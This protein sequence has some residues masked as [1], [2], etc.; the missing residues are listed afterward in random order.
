MTFDPWSKLWF[1]VGGASRWRFHAFTFPTN[2]QLAPLASLASLVS[3]APLA[4]TPPTR[5][6]RAG[7]SAEMRPTCAAAVFP[8]K[9]TSQIKITEAPDRGELAAAA[10]AKGAA[11]STPPPGEDRVQK[12]GNAERGEGRH[13]AARPG[14]VTFASTERTGGCPARTEHAQ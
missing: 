10:A 6:S 11:A 1:S 12:A 8:H 14:G 9:Q 2:S 4:P 13:A 5:S 3:L 7:V